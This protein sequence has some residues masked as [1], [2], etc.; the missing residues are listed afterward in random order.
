MPTSNLVR[1][2]P[3]ALRKLWPLI[4]G[5]LSLAVNKNRGEES[6]EDVFRRVDTGVSVLFVEKDGGTLWSAV[7]VTLKDYPN[8]RIANVDYLVGRYTS[9]GWRALQSACK[10]LGANEI[11]AYCGPAEARL[12]HRYGMAPMYTVMGVDL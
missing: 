5:P 11:R 8:L 3:E 12:F 7:V 1:V 10:A 4:E 6:I 2:P 9:G